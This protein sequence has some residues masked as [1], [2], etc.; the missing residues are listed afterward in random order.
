MTATLPM[1]PLSGP[2]RK[3]EGRVRCENGAHRCTPAT[4]SRRGVTM[5]QATET[6]MRTTPGA[7]GYESE[8]DEIVDRAAEAGERSGHRHERLRSFLQRYYRHVPIE[9]L[10][11][12]EPLDLAGAALSHRQLATHRPQGTA[13]VRVFTPTVDE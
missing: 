4:G 2:G 9:D 7:S 13:N 10:A 8:R 11:E 12:R 6:T 1:K 3:G 5:S